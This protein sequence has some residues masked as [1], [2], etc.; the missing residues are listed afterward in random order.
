MPGPE[1]NVGRGQRAMDEQGVAG[2]HPTQRS[3]RNQGHGCHAPLP[4]AVVATNTAIAQTRRQVLVPQEAADV[5]EGPPR[6]RIDSQQF[7]DP[8]DG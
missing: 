5:L 3:G 4:L 6:D 1:A 7:T 8:F 2:M